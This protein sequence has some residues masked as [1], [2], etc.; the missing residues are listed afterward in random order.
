MWRGG[1]PPLGCAATPKSCDCFAA[2]RGQAP[3]PQASPLATGKPTLHR[4]APLST[5]KFH[6]PQASPLAMS[7]TLTTNEWVLLNL[8]PAIQNCVLTH[9][10]I[11]A[12]PRQAKPNR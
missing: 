12:T 9:E 3:S 10:M 7:K 4:K 6:S 2:E 1:L 11:S 8:L 5:G